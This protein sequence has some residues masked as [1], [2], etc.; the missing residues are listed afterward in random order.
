M[1]ATGLLTSWFTFGI[2]HMPPYVFKRTDTRIHLFGSALTALSCIINT[3]NVPQSY[4]PKLRFLHSYIGRIGCIA[5]FIGIMGGLTRIYSIYKETGTINGQMFG[6]TYAAMMQAYYTYKLA[7]AAKQMRE[8]KE[9]KEENENYAKDMKELAEIHID[10]AHNLFY[11]ACIGPFLTRALDPQ[12]V[13]LGAVAKA[14]QDI[15]GLP[16]AAMTVISMAGTALIP[17][18]MISNAQKCLKNGTYV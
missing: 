3:A 15:T 5:S 13:P 14:V 2:K 10:F 1:G 6:L 16:D 12:E 7:T 18:F 17:T 4:S 9:S 11:G 8:L